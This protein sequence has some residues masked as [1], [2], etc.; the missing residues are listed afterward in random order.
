MVQ[1]QTLR[2]HVPV[3]ESFVPSIKGGMEAKLS[4]D[5]HPGK[6]FA[7]KISRTSNSV[8][9][10]SRTMLVE[11][12]VPNPDGL[13]LPGMYAQVTFALQQEAP[14]LLMPSNA[15]LVRP[16]GMLAAVVGKDKVVHYKKIQVGRDYGTRIEVVSG[17]EDGDQV[18][19]NPTTM[20]RDGEKVE[21]ASQGGS[22]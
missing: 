13:L 12:R 19:V 21:P 16:E 1:L 8:D 20:I 10:A 11:V 17:L 6:S 9:P 5:A 3:P 15:L 4:F 22:P 18:M 2:F 14:P 7:G